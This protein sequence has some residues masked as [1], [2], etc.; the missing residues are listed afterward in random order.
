MRASM[1]PLLL[2]YHVDLVFSGH[3]HA[4]ERSVPVYQQTPTDGAPTYITIGDGSQISQSCCFIFILK[5][6]DT[7]GNRE[8][9]A[10]D[11]YPTASWSAYHESAF[12]HGRLELLNSTHAHW[13][14]QKNV[15]SVSDLLTIQF[16]MFIPSRRFL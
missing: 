15:D 11:W 3:V 16:C 7:G 10:D 1:E 13:S 8:G 12:G 14:W 2:Q 5:I 9:T 6:W 4:Y